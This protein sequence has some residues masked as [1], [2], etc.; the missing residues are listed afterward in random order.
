MWAALF[1]WNLSPSTSPVYEMELSDIKAN[2]Q[3]LAGIGNCKA[4][5]IY[6]QVIM[7]A[8]KGEHVHV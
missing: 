6:I 1:P 2:P 3:C 7:N 5:E 4:G 8:L